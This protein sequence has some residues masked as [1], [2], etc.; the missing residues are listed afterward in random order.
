MSFNTGTSDASIGIL[1]L[2]TQFPRIPGDLGN[3]LSW[4]FPVKFKLVSGASARTALS[5]DPRTL[6]QPFIIAAQELIEDGADGITTS[7][8]FLSLMQQELSEAI[9]VPL[10]TSSLMQIPWVQSLLPQHQ[11][12]GVLT[13]DS[14]SLTA[15]HLL[16][17]GARTDTPVAGTENGSE[18]SR[19]I[20]N[21]E[22]TMNVELCRAD[23]V[24][25]ARRL[26]EEHPD[27]AAIVLECTNMAPYAADIQRETGLPVFSIVTLINWFQTGLQPRNF[28]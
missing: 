8:G 2:D 19:V 28:C 6:L 13:I 27:V 4:P 16:A 11:R 3:E 26:I 20:L 22:P 10:L 9:P 24:N 5:E 1:M 23:N 12:V 15:A 25:A 14:R 17:A 7:C 21:D 18:F